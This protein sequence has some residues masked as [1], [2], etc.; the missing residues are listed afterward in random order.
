MR[1]II[2]QTQTSGNSC[3]AASVAMLVGVPVISVETL[4]NDRLHAGE[5]EIRDVLKHY[6]VEFTRLYADEKI[7]SDYL[8]MVQACSLTEP[9]R[10]HMVLLD[11]RT[12][13]KV[14][15]PAM[16]FTDGAYEAAYYYWRDDEPP[17]RKGVCLSSFVPFFRI[18]NKE[19][20]DDV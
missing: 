13:V 4:F 3:V 9:G 5:V 14:Y 11:A 17:T 7:H 15:D 2:H 12:S 8:Y 19:F 1:Q 18:E 16:G 20:Y 6:G 10:F